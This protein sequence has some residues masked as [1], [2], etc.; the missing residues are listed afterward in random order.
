MDQELRIDQ[1][2]I[3]TLIAAQ[4]PQ[5][6]HLPLAPAP[7][8]GT[9][10]A[11]F[12]LGADMA[13]RLPRRASAAEQA[14]KE[15]R[16]LPA[17]APHLPLPIPAPLAMGEPGVDYPWRWSICRWIEGEAATSSPFDE[18]PA[19]RDLAAF[20]G[21]LQRINPKDA[22]PP[23]PHNFFRGVPLARRDDATRAAIP[24]LADMLDTGAL[25]SVWELALRAPAWNGAPVWIHGDLHPG[26]ILVRKGRI[27]GVIDFGGLCAGD[28]ACD[29]MAAWTMFGPGG[30]AA[31]RN[32]LD[33]DEAS[34]SRARGWALSFGAIALAFYRD[35]N[36]VL[37]H[38]ARHAIEQ[39]L[40][41]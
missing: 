20:V 22:P 9:D 39:A 38:I 27:S 6:K 19:A 26:N 29:L 32:A 15:Q 10:N 11:I 23:G 21:A 17:L 41:E 4:F 36:P 2:L 25:M 35:R 13:V 30:R 37:A 5:W 14:G 34:W 16:F 40:I 18:I 3:Q 33:G 12:R 8:T 24:Q 1:A 28:P 7:A 31:F